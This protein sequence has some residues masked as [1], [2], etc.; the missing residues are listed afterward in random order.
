[1]L[2]ATFAALQTIFSSFLP[3]ASGQFNIS[4]EHPYA[5][6]ETV[7]AVSL[8]D[9]THQLEL[10]TASKVIKQSQLAEADYRIKTIVIDAGHGGH[11]PGCLG[12]SFQEKNLALAI[13]LNTRDLISSQFPEIKVIMTRDSDFFVPLY[14]RANIANRANADLF[15][16][17]HCNFMPGSSATKG[18]ETY[19]MGLHTAQQNLEVAKRE[20]SAILLEDDYEQNYDFDPNS[21]EGH[22]MLSLFQNAHL[23]QSIFLAER[24]ESQFG[25]QKRK[26]RGVRQAGFYVLK[27]T[28][29]PSI[30]I[31][32]GFLSNREEE[33]FLATAD[34]QSTIATA[35]F[36]AFCEYKDGMELGTV[37]TDA[38]PLAAAEEQQTVVNVPPPGKTSPSMVANKPKTQ[39]TDKQI[40]SAPA[41][42]SNEPKVVAI[43]N[44]GSTSV[45]PVVQFCIQLAAASQPV[46]G[47]QSRW[48]D[49]PYP[50]EAVQEDN[51]YKYQVRGYTDLEVALRAKNDLKNLGFRD[52]FLVA[53]KNEKRISIEEAKQALGIQY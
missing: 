12:A 44:T 30:L 49:L 37:S 26:S 33:N 43:R 32:A 13:A 38:P 5:A 19:V 29:M 35:I 27:G 52:A 42:S 17:I 7:H 41:P 20:N 48:N 9:T 53:Y 4:L 24:V 22:I 15:I 18:T 11:D 47:S 39:T 40:N 46:D 14:E 3:S 45:M 23:D 21:P 2:I 50:I 31:E 36:K 8:K 10:Q 51:L 34:G 28:T 1:M 6:L 25:N 16:S